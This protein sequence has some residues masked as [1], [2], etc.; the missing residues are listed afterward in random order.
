[1]SQF[2]PDNEEINNTI[3]MFN[4]FMIDA[5][6]SDETFCVNIKLL[7]EIFDIGYNSITN[8]YI[9]DAINSAR[10][11]V[12]TDY[13]IDDYEAY[14][15]SIDA[16]KI[17]LLNLNHNDRLPIVICQSYFDKY[18]NHYMIYQNGVSAIRRRNSIFL[19]TVKDLDIGDTR[20]S[21]YIE[22]IVDVM[23]TEDNVNSIL[24]QVYQIEAESSSP[25]YN[26]QGSDIEINSE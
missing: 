7:L 5:T 12:D 2:N 13:T 16:S 25:G 20:L 15:L 23:T 18:Y 14:L 6:K 21:Q 26:T 24:D 22:S 17:L 11:V 3:M 9:D 1:M 4:D 19:E 8:E 10:L